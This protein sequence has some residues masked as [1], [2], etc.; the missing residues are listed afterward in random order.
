MVYTMKF[1]YVHTQEDSLHFL[2]EL[3]GVAVAREPSGR[4]G[5]GLH[6]V[7]QW[8]GLVEEE[9]GTANYSHS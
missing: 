1:Q 7:R 3:G 4:E 5:M 6:L 9:L 8:D 2:S